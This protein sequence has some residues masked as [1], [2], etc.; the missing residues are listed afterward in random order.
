[1]QGAAAEY[2]GPRALGAFGSVAAMT[3]ASFFR[4]IGDTRTPLV[5]M[6]VAVLA[7]VVLDYALIFGHFGLPALGVAGA[8]LATAIAE[9]GTAGRAPIV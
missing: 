9:S 5:A 1:M 3:L 4:G 7:N 8:G 2:V 6:V